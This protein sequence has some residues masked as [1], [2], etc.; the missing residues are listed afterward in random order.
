MKRLLCFALAVVLCL[1]FSVQK[2]QILKELQVGMS[3]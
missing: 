3:S 2:D 1:T